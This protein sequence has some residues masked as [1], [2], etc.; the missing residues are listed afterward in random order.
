MWLVKECTSERRTFV[1]WR[2]G[3]CLTNAVWCEEGKKMLEVRI[4]CS[5]GLWGSVSLLSEPSREHP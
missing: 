4:S 3:S 1:T 5:P 2:S